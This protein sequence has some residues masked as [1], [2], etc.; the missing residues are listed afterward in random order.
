MYPL[1]NMLRTITDKHVY[2]WYNVCRV[3]QI[4]DIWRRLFGFIDYGN[5][6]EICMCLSDIQYMELYLYSGIINVHHRTTRFFMNSG[7]SYLVTNEQLSTEFENHR[8]RQKPHFVLLNISIE[9]SELRHI[10]ISFVRKNI[11]Q[12]IFKK[13]WHHK[14]L[15]ILLFD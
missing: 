3:N 5:V 8:F 15:F 10:L 12:K 9:C 6:L 1:F 4:S 7:T 2:L 11:S 14:F 13:I